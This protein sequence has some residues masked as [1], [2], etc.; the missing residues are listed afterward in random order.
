MPDEHNQ[1]Q[2]TKD[3]H[4]TPNRFVARAFSFDY[5]VGGRIRRLVGTCEAQTF[6]GY[7]EPG[8]IPDYHLI[9]RGSSGKAVTISLVENRAHFHE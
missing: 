8:H 3:P 5:E 4:P 6:I 1:P 9:I 7:A 2:P